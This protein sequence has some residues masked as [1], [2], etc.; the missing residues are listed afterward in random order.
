M[1]VNSG[2]LKLCRRPYTTEE[3]R[4]GF[5]QAIANSKFMTIAK[6]QQDILTIWGIP[7]EKVYKYEFLGKVNDNN[8]HTE[9]IRAGNG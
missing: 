9:D 2:Y 3:S 6:S 4:E 8:Y 1:A 7:M 5:S